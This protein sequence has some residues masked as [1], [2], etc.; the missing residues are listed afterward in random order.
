MAIYFPCIMVAAT[1]RS[2]SPEALTQ[3]M[4]AGPAAHCARGGTSFLAET[5]ALV[6]R[7]LGEVR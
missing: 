2:I 6:A 1:L 7:G 3:I 5:G 4:R